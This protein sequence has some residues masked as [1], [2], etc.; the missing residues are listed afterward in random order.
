MIFL[1]VCFALGAVVLIALTYIAA[2]DSEENSMGVLDMLAH[3]SLWG[4]RLTAAAKKKPCACARQRFRMAA[5]LSYDKPSAALMMALLSRPGDLAGV[6]VRQGASI[7]KAL[8]EMEQSCGM[9]VREIKGRVRSLD[10]LYVQLV[11]PFR[12]RA[13]GEEWVNNRNAS[14]TTDRNRCVV[15]LVPVESVTSVAGG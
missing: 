7:A 3:R 15:W 9:V 14:P 8:R 4:R 11:Q 6:H 5:S 10:A 2:T 13:R 12:E 1:L